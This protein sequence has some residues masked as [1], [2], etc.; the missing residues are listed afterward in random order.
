MTKRRTGV[1]ESI[2]F[3]AA[4]RKRFLSC[5]H[6][7][8]VKN[9][10]KAQKEASRDRKRYKHQKQVSELSEWKKRALALEKFGMYS[11][12]NDST[13]QATSSYGYQDEEQEATVIVT[14]HD[15]HDPCSL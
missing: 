10:L 2:S 13:S 7:K 8:K 6:G 9:R 15:D 4:S 11:K 1:I 3:D 12:N 5:E 14:K